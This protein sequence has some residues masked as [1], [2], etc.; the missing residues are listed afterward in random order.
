M[1]RIKLFGKLIVQPASALVEIKSRQPYLF[2]IMLALISAVIYRSGETGIFRDL[3]FL[4]FSRSRGGALPLLLWGIVPSVLREIVPLVL[5]AGLFVPLGI[6]IVN[7]L[8]PRG[9]LGIVLR[10]EY[11]GVLACIVYSWAAA[12]VLMAAPA[13]LLFNSRHELYS[14][15]LFFAPLPYF[16]L[17]AVLAFREGLRVSTARAVVTA[18]LAIV[19]VPALLLGTRVLFSFVPFIILIWFVI[20]MRGYLSDILAAQRARANF[21]RNLEAAT[22]NPADASAHYN[23]GLI[24]Q[25][26]GE[27]EDAINSFERAIEIDPDE[28]DAAYQLA[29]I[30][31]DQAMYGDAISLFDRVVR[32]NMDY[33]QSEVWREIGST[34]YGA[35]QLEDAREAFERFLANRPSDAEGKYRYG[36]TLFRLGRVDDALGQM[37]GVIE[38]VKTSPAY[39]YRIERRWMIEAQSFLRSQSA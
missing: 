13:I 38:T 5:L 4:I 29:K 6:M 7:F 3:R 21:R 34:Y 1:H 33:A 19:T 31:R 12:N 25:S 28:I 30:K 2:G 36:L 24:Y 32:Y 27:T 35:N 15:A 23:L 8:D 16:G 9:T 14:Q 10:K 26:H 22:L 37:Q 39:K 17:L 11:L 20:L 18:F